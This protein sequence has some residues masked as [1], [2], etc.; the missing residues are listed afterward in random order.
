M[1]NSYTG[2]L[3]QNKIQILQKIY[4]NPLHP[5]SFGSI[6]KLFESARQRDPN[7]SI[8][9]VKYWLSEQPT[10]TI[11][12]Q[13]RRHFK[14]NRVVVE[15]VNEQFQADLLDMRKLSK[16]NNGFNYILTAVD[17]LSKYG[18]AIPVRN[19]RSY[20]LSSAFKKIFRE[21][22]PEKI[23]TDK[24]KE[25]LN[26]EVS[27][28]FLKNNIHHFT[29]NNTEIK[30]SNVE[31]FNRT[32][33]GRLAKYFTAYHTKKWTNILDK[34]VSSYNNSIHRTTKFKP[35]EVN[36][37]NKDIVFK[38][39]YG[40]NS[41]REYIKSM[42]GISNTKKGD[43]VRIPYQR[44]RFLR[45]R[46]PLWGE[47]ILSVNDVVKGGVKP[48]HILSNY[49]ETHKRYYPEEVQKVNKPPLNSVKK[50]LKTRFKK[51]GRE[52]L[53]K[54]AGYPLQYTSWQPGNYLFKDE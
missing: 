1:K 37:K 21:R 10:Y 52:Y 39:I 12:K 35:S 46:L 11:H 5:S 19:K 24:G 9:D 38:N 7:I 51:G 42:H 41:M 53:V 48:L 26:K 47:E 23:Q 54:F 16:F 45:G 30:C 36:E 40:F 49:E 13:R 14:R 50:I 44:T 2:G 43:L 15:N 20:N 31:R 3:S 34:I 28:L 33:R 22:I 8:D 17:I 32:L 29:S 6:K 27:K 25:F 18:F 4:Y